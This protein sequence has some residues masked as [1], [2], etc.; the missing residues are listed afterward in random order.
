MALNLPT[1]GTLNSL[2]AADL[3]GDGFSDILIG[4]G[5]AY[6]QRKYYDPSTHVQSGYTA[7]NTGAIYV[8]FGSST[9]GASGAIDLTGLSAPN[10]VIVLG[11]EDGDAFTPGIGMHM[12]V[13]DINGDTFPDVI[14]GGT[15]YYYNASASQGYYTDHVYVIFGQ[16]PAKVPSIPAFDPKGTVVAGRQATR[17]KTSR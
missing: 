11:P 9:L 13:G 16:D 12:I 1:Y 3:N 7:Y 5:S 17:S 6:I 10:G 15:S 4:S 2:A 14:V 8:V